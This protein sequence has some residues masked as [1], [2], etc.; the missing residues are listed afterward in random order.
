MSRPR[1]FVD[2]DLNETI[3]DGVLRAEPLV[4]FVLAREVGMSDRSDPEV[5]EYA[6]GDGL[7]VLSHDVNTMSA[8][9]K[10]RLVAGQSFPGLM[11]IPQEHPI[12]QIIDDL[13]LIWAA[14]EAEEWEDQNRYFPLK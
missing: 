12:G 7:I 3:V 2:H 8:A 4:E 14:S 1:F 13:V 11:L 6:A 9:A 5:L 10:A